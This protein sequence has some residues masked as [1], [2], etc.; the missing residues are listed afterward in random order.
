[1][2]TK[3]AFQE[4]K[5]LFVLMII[6]DAPDGITGYQLQEKYDIPRGNLIRTLDELE[7]NKYVSTREAVENGRNLKYYTITAEGKAYVE[8]LK[9]EWA[10]RFAM[11]SEIAPPDI[12]GNPFMREGPKRRMFK[13]IEKF[14]SKEDALDYF[15]GVRSMLKSV[16]ARIQERLKRT[17]DTKANI[18]S[19]IQEIEKMDSFDLAKIKDLIQKVPREFGEPETP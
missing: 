9:E 13:N 6:Q 4:I 3:E 16:I 14:T 17:E 15:H 5:H 7:E 18:D 11:L 1:L 10:N 2:L 8:K 19:I 12:H